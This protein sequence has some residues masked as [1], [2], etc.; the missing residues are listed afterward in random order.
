MSKQVPI[1][2]EISRKK[3]WPFYVLMVTVLLTMAWFLPALY[4]PYAVLAA[5]A[6]IIVYMSLARAILSRAH[7]RGMRLIKQHQFG[8]ALP[9]FEA[10]LAFFTRNGWLDRWR[11]LVLLS[12]SAMSYREMALCNMA[13]CYSQT[14]RG[15]EATELY[16]RILDEFPENGMAEAALNMIRSVEGKNRK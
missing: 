10:S 2:H 15:Q 14:G 12:T 9:H 4:I 8:E 5:M 7:R 13:F 16:E 11:S 1:I 6:V 3:S